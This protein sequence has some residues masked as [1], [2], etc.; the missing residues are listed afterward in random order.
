MAIQ[1]FYSPM[2]SSNRV[3]WALEELGVPYDKHRLNLL[4]GDQKKP[5]FL[6]INPNGKIPALVDG[7]AKVF[8]SHAI[9]MWLGER[10]GEDKGLWPKSGTP[11][12]ADAY[13]W[14]TWAIVNL[15]P[16][17]FTYAMHTNDEARFALPKD[18]RSAAVAEASKESFAQ[19]MTLLDARMNGRDYILGKQFSLADV[20]VV[21][22]AMVAPMMAKLSLDAYPHVQAWVGRCMQR[23]A[24]GRV[25]SEG[26]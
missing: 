21:T 16:A 20:A 17:V 24:L 8:E 1:F 22:M 15:M 9:L 2:S 3:H 11:E 13:S 25:M 12:R 6:A 23:P 7:D 10:Y 26:R 5:A 19:L 14:S 4:E 18:K